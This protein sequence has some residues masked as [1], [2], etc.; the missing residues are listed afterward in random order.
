MHR[1]I[2]I[3]VGLG[4]PG[5]QFHYTRHNI[6]FLVLDALADKYGVSW[7][8]KGDKEV[9]EIVVHDKK[10]MLV[11]PQTFMNNSGK[12]VPGL[13]KHGV[14]VENLLV[15]HDELEKTFGVVD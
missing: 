13:L 10:I 1:D 5:R 15:V 6:G 4:N 9:A 11:K 8:A 7:Q 3:I 2:K 14:T 12:V